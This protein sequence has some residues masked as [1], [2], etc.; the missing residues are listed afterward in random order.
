LSHAIESVDDPSWCDL[1]G[2]Q[3]DILATIGRLEVQDKE[4]L[5][6]L[7]ILDALDSARSERVHHGRLYPNLHALADRGLLRITSYDSRTN[8]YRLTPEAVD[9]L[10]E[11][12]SRLADACWMHPAETDGGDR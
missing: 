11:R 9:M 6:G 2:F 4:V 1:T 10:H 8:E 5:K 12:A 3:R 7:A